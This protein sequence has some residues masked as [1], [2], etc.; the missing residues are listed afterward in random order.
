MVQL[1]SVDVSQC[2][3]FLAHLLWPEA[4]HILAQT[5]IDFG[6]GLIGPVSLAV[7]EALHHSRNA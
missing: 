6:T 4:L 7:S 2:R 5:F 3:A 1:T